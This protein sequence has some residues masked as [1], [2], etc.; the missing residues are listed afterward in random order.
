MKQWHPAPSEWIAELVKVRWTRDNQAPKVVAHL[1]MWHLLG[2]GATVT[3]RDL[4]DY[5]GWSKWKAHTFQREALTFRNDWVTHDSGQEPDKN[6]TAGPT[7]SDTCEPKPDKN[8]TETGHSRG[9]DPLIK[10]TPLQGTEKSTSNLGLK[11]LWDQV[12]DIRKQAGHRRPLKLNQARH[13]VLAARVTEYS[14]AEVLRVVSWWMFSKHE[15]A[16]FLR[17]KG[18]TIATILRASNFAD[19]LDFAHEP[20]PT[21]APKRKRGAA[22][23]SV[24][25]RL[26][27]AEALRDRPP[28]VVVEF[29]PK[30]GADNG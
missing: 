29:T 24:A 2:S 23:V 30:T 14:E 16:T 11:D 1:W 20:E 25:D 8:R 13:R 9:R 19:Y 21:H 10:T 18:L 27:E 6:R 7:I 28:G 15:R 5:T 17:Q 4:M 26:A 3:V 12:N 22:Y